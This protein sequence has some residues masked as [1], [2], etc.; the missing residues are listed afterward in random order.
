[1]PAIKI[2]KLKLIFEKQVLH[3]FLLAVLLTGVFIVSRIDGFMSGRFLNISTP[4]WFYSA[5]V[6]AVVHQV[7]VW[8]CWRMQLHFSLITNKYGHRGFIYYSIGFMVLFVL[9]F[10]AVAMLAISNINTLNAS[11]LL[12]NILALIIAIPVLYLLYSVIRYF[13]IER[14]LGIDH[15]DLSY[16]KKPFVKKGIFKYTDNGMYFFGLLAFWIP[17]LLCSSGAALLL[18]LFNHLYVWVHYYTTEKPDFKRI[19]GS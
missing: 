4:V 8:F 19:Y 5:I 17:G 2:G 15:F 9:R 18:A 14:A 13:T 11:Q 16:G 12:L 1:M 10:V 3:Y 6:I 7:Y